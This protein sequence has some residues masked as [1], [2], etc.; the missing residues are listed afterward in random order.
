MFLKSHVCD[1][2]VTHI[3]SKLSKKARII[4]KIDISMELIVLPYRIKC[5][6][7]SIPS[8]GIFDFAVDGCRC[9]TV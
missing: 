9:Q 8:F 5:N 1:C 7:C 2:E 4:D 3:T 6:N